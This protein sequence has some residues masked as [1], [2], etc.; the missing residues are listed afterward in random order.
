MTVTERA[1]DPERELHPAAAWRDLAAAALL[2]GIGVACGHSTVLGALD[3]LTVLFD[4]AA[5]LGASWGVV[6]IVASRLG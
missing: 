2:F 4:G 6:R 3:E 1:A 5:L